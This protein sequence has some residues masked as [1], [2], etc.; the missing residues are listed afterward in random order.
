M[1]VAIV[2]VVI[3]LILVIII[4]AIQLI[5]LM[6]KKKNKVKWIYFLINLSFVALFDNIYS[7]VFCL[8]FDEI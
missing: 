3:V 5:F 7:I 8:F 6:N 2:V 1:I 4:V